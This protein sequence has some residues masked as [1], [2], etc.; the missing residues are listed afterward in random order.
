MRL[1]TEVVTK[2]TGCPTVGYVAGIMTPE[3]AE[4]ISP[5][6]KNGCPWDE[7]YPQWREKPVIWVRFK[8]PQRP[9]S[10]EEFFQQVPQ[11]MLEGKSEED[12]DMFY[13]NNVPILK[14]ALY[15]FDDL[16]EF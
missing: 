16:E 9:V 14:M 11:E 1:N 5:N 10:K 4:T 13:Q 12:K 6:I 3:V 15:P 8:K 2:K 7:V